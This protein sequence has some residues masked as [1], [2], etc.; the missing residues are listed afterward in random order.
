VDVRRA[1]LDVQWTV[2]RATQADVVELAPVNVA[3]WR[4]AYRGIVPDQFLEEMD[5]A[6]RRQSLSQ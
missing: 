5:E 2:R 6:S 4:E 1:A 3:A